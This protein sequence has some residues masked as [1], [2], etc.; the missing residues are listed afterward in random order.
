MCQRLP[1]IEAQDWTDDIDC[2][3][4]RVLVIGSGS[5]AVTLVPELAK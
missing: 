5:T 4:K 3:N 1:L 2:T